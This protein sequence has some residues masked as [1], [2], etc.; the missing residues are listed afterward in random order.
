MDAGACGVAA[1]VRALVEAVELL[2]FDATITA[3]VVWLCGAVVLP[4]LME[5]RYRARPASPSAGLRR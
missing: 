1:V 4:G 3:Q 2:A 5:F